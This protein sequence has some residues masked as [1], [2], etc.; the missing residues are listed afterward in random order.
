M[1]IIKI[2]LNLILSFLLIVL[3]LVNLATNIL[4]NKLLNKNYVLSKME[5]TE[6]YLQI[7]REVENGFENYIYQSGL[8]EDTIKDLFTEEMI[9]NDSNS[10]INSVYEGSEITLS[11]EQ[12]K[13]T[14]DKK[15]DDYLN[16]Q[17][18]KMNKQGKDNIKKFENLVVKEYNKNVNASTTLYETAHSGIEK[19]NNINNKIGNIPLTALIVVIILLII[20]NIKNLLDA[21]KFVGISALSAGILM[22][23]GIKVILDSVSL[24]NIVLLTT[25][26]TNL[27]IT[28]VKDILYSIDDNSGLFIVGGITAILLTAIL[29]NVNKAKSKEN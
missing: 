3:I 9:R 11:T 29:Q 23:L 6:F 28:M 19:L 7:S 12:V 21:I 15:I 10:L 18:I 1:K 13:E 16:S 2:I 4:E 25:S 17:N 8:P 5:E 24:D 27:F 22:K 26:L 14:L 20:I